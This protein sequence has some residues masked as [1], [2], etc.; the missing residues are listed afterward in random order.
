MFSTNLVYEDGHYLMMYL[1]IHT[2]FI[3][4]SLTFLLVEY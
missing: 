1:S 2:Q 3:H 4:F